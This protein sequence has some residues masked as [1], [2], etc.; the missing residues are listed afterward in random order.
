[1][2]KFGQW[3]YGG[4]VAAFVVAL[5]VLAGCQTLKDAVAPITPVEVSQPASPVE[6]F[7]Q[8]VAVAQAAINEGRAQNWEA[9]AVIGDR[10]ESGVWTK[11]IAQSY[12][13]KVVEFSKRLDDAQTI[14]DAGNVAGAQSEA[15]LIK[16]GIKLLVAEVANQ[17]AKE[18][19]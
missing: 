6:A 5:L 2:S 19:Q 1:M 12:L 15:E 4:L 13:D 16:A 9:A 17:A 14:L 7:A 10:V 11:P 3:V 18:T 8:A